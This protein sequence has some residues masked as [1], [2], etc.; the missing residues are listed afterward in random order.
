MPPEAASTTS[1][2][3]DLHSLCEHIALHKV[4]GLLHTLLLRESAHFFGSVLLNSTILARTE[5]SIS[6][7]SFAVT[8][9][10]I[11]REIR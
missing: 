1:A 8:C 6:A 2:L 10:P 7:P 9:R 5:E 4:H 11:E 3:F